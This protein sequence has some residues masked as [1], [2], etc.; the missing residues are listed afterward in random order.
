MV[1]VFARL[2][3][4]LVGA[5]VILAATAWGALRYA[6][7]LAT[8]RVAVSPDRRNFPLSY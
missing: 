6:E 5:L 8:L 7:R 1:S 2:F 4:R 3:G